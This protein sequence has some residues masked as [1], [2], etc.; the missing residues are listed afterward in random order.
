MGL[1]AGD[2]TEFRWMLESIRTGVRDSRDYR[3]CVR[4]NMNKLLCC[5]VNSQVMD[6]AEY[7]MVLDI[8][9]A[10]VTTNYGCVDLATRHG[11]LTWCSVLVSQEKI[12]K[13][14]IRQIIR[15]S[16]QVMETATR[17]DRSKTI[18]EVNGED[19]SNEQQNKTRLLVQSI[20]VPLKSLV[21]KLKC[22]AMERNELEMLNEISNIEL[23]C[24]MY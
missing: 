9:L 4:S 17:I 6:R 18:S 16:Q 22:V 21:E 1:V 12:D 24:P 7:L 15:I 2:K 8:I 20:R 3:L 23:K 14:Y 10:S 13:A 5:L 19:G 11:L